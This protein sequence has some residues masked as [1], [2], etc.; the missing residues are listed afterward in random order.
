M[1]NAATGDDASDRDEG[2]HQGRPSEQLRIVN[3]DGSLGVVFD[4][5]DLEPAWNWLAEHPA[6]AAGF[7]PTAERPAR[8]NVG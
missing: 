6:S 1:T 2:E 4:W 5:S 3:D 7:E 8:A